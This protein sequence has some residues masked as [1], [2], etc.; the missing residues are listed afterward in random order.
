MIAKITKRLIDGLGRPDRVTIIYDMDLKGFGVRLAQTGYLSWFVEYRPGAG[1][2]NTAKRRMVL[3]SR[4][5]TPEQARIA[6]KRI[7]ASVSLGTDPAGDRRRKR[8]MPTVREF[9]SRFLIEEA[10]TKLK[11]GTVQN[12]G[13]YLNK[14]AIPAIGSTKLDALTKAEIARLHS[15]VGQIAP[16]TANRIIECLSSLYRYAATCGLVPHDQNPIRG[17]RKFREN[18]RER[19]LTSNE[20]ESLGAAIR[21]AETIGV[22]W[23]IDNTKLTAKHV[24]KNNR[25][26]KLGPHA[27]AALRLLIFTGARL[28]EI[29]HLRWEYVD[30]ERG[31]LLLPDSKTGRKTIVLNAPALAVLATLPHIGAYVI[32]GESAGTKKEKPRFDLQRPWQ[33]I[34]KHAGLNG[35]R[36]HDLRHT[37]AS[38]GARAGLGLPIIGKL[39]GHAH[40]NTTQRYAHLDNDP[41]RRA[42]EQ[43]GMQLAVAMGEHQSIRRMIL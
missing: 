20:L 8:E 18:R 37:H 24:P 5:L 19:F 25:R 27:A 26:T 14:H 35:V 31:L 41:L 15:R 30:F 38:F 17:I 16:M 13:I 36:I 43:I 12:Y 23:N 11:P 22:P 28:R 4:E 21:E 33:M 6:A 34:A 39:L 40:P 2:R 1:G 3:G 7:L 29:L 9:A 10:A 32:A 42:S